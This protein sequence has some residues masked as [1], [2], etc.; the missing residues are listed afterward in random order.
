M[1]VLYPI[2]EAIVPRA[3]KSNR[4]ADLEMDIIILVGQWNTQPLVSSGVTDF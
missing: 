4:L 3:F 1:Y 2:K